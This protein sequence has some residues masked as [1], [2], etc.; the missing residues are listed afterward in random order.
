MKMDQSSGGSAS[1]GRYNAKRRP[2]QFSEKSKVAVEAVFN[3]LPE[4]CTLNWAMDN[5]CLVTVKLD[6]Q[7]AEECMSALGFV[8]MKRCKK[9]KPLQTGRLWWK[10]T[11]LVD[12][13][14]FSGAVFWRLEDNGTQ[15][16]TDMGTSASML[17]FE[18]E[19]ASNTEGYGVYIRMVSCVIGGVPVNTK[20]VSG[21]SSFTSFLTEHWKCELPLGKNVL[22]CR[23]IQWGREVLVVLPS[24]LE[25]IATRGYVALE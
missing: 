18:I 3:K 14:E 21:A 7:A 6:I 20:S 4:G 2:A 5:S 13:E 25:E 17:I 8:A 22:P 12:D 16:F 11:S 24:E 15:I 9:M 1:L 19:V 10:K 23:K